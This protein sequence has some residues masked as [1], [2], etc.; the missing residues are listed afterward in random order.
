MKPGELQRLLLL[1]TSINYDVNNYKL[2]RKLNF[3]C[4][5]H[6]ASESVVDDVVLISFF[7]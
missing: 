4:A 3:T 1:L 6:S 7:H 5:M 2:Q